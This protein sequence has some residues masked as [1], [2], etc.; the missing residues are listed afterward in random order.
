MTSIRGL[1]ALNP[2]LLMGGTKWSGTLERRPGSFPV[3]DRSFRSMILQVF[4]A[5]IPRIQG[6]RLPSVLCCLLPVV[7]FAREEEGEWITRSYVVGKAPEFHQTATRSL[8][9]GGGD[10]FGFGGGSSSK[11]LPESDLP[12]ARKTA[13]PEFL[14]EYMTHYLGVAFPEGS[15]IRYQRAGHVLHMR[16]TEVQHELLKVGLMRHRMLPYQVQLSVRMVSFPEKRMDALERKH[17]AGIP[18][19]ELLELWQKGEGETLAFQ[20]VKTINGVNVILECVE[21][22][23]YPTEMDR[24]EVG[25]D[26]E[27]KRS[28][29]IYGGFE[30]RDVGAILNV[31]P[32]VGQDFNTLNLVLLPES[33]ALKG[34]NELQ[35]EV[36]RPATP[37]FHSIN[38]TTSVALENGAV[39]VLG[40][41]TDHHSGRRIVLFGSGRLVDGQGRFIEVPREIPSAPAAKEEK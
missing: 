6:M 39:L 20:S 7:L 1:F 41:S 26:G 31:T 34:A 16:N 23:I 9:G 12:W 19:A 32:T 18:D 3:P 22:I 2:S 14:E 38:V 33:A 17:A 35:P 21:E 10:P 24:V 37:V 11:S 8:G 36:N 30:T 5:K 13:N 4:F 15:W 29:W 28:D 27:E 25:D 40:Q